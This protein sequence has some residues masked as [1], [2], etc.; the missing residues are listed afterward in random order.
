[1]K[2][3]ALV[4]SGGKSRGGSVGGAGGSGGGRLDIH[5]NTFGVRSV[6]SLGDAFEVS[7]NDWA[8]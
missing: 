6:R 8:I 7:G 1:M 3:A 2:L 5:G 4:R